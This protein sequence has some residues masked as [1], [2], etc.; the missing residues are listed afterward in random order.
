LPGG[1]CV[2]FSEQVVLFVDDTVSVEDLAVDVDDPARL[3]LHMTQRG[4]AGE[5]RER[6]VE[7]RG[8][9]SCGGPYWREPL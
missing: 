4:P 5:E 6:W 3:A 9:L 7:L 2:L 8:C 1:A